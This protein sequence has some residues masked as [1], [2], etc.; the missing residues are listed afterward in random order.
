[1]IDGKQRQLEAI[2]DSRLVEDIAQ[3]MFDRLLAD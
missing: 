2:G 1:M 3:M